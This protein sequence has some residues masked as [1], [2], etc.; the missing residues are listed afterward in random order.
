[1][2]GC[3][4]VVVRIRNNRNSAACEKSLLTLGFWDDTDSCYTDARFENGQISVGPVHH[5]DSEAG[6][7]EIGKAEYAR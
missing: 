2:D 7:Y 1:M 4:E 5:Y 6:Y 3:T